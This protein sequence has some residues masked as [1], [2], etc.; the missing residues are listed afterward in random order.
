MVLSDN[1]LAKKKI[2]NRKP[3]LKI[4]RRMTISEQEDSESE[5]VN[6]ESGQKEIQLI[7]NKIKK[8]KRKNSTNH[9]QSHHVEFDNKWDKLS[10]YQAKKKHDKRMFLLRKRFSVKKPINVIFSFV[11]IFCLVKFNEIFGF[12]QLLLPSLQQELV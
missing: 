2:T 7:R 4:K 3:I 1:K 9:L 10:N 6:N 12:Y 8:K 5:S 11:L